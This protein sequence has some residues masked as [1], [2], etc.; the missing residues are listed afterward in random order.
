MQ[1]RL[2]MISV[3]ADSLRSRYQTKLGRTVY[4]RGGIAPDTVV[5]MPDTP[6][7]ITQLRHSLAFFK[8]ATRYSAGMRSSQNF[9]VDNALIDAFEQFAGTTSVASDRDDPMLIKLKELEDV[10]HQEKYGDE[11]HRRIESLRI[12]LGSEQHRAFQRYREE[13]RRELYNEISGRFHGQRE[14]LEAMLADDHQL[15]AAVSLLHSGR[16]S[17]GRLLSVR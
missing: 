9:A 14:R 8:F 17:Y 13:I 10:A 7:I 4:E 15:Q 12:E 6:A 3:L 2:G 11:I 5:E 1:Q 16:H